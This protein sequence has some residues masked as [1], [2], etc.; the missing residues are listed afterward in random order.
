MKKNYAK[1]LLLLIILF[2]GCS[3]DLHTKHLVVKHLKNGSKITIINGYMELS[4]TENKGVVFGLFNQKK[5]S[6]QYYLLI[7]LNSMA[8][9]VVLYLIWRL[10][11][12]TFFQLLPFFIMLSG[13]LGNFINRILYGSVVDFIHIHIKDIINWPFLFNLADVLINF[14]ITLLLILIV[15]NKLAF[16]KIFS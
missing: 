10:R 6:F 8:I 14:G 11:E 7:I 1:F 15:F 16:K 4:Y 5:S 13:A 12:L 3:S 2:T 9:G